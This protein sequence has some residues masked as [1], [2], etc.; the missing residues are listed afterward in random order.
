MG[1]HGRLER[2]SCNRPVA[3][4]HFDFLLML[5]DLLLKIF[6][7]FNQK[8]ASLFVAIVAAPRFIAM[9]TK[10]RSSSLIN[11]F[12][13][14]GWLGAR[15]PRDLY[16]T[17]LGVVLIL[18]ASWLS[19]SW[20]MPKEI[21]A[22]TMRGCHLGAVRV[23]EIGYNGSILRL[24]GCPKNDVVGGSKIGRIFGVWEKKNNKV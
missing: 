17:S 20:I 24:E 19:R 18:R 9:P 8:K 15:G 14:E 10:V 3:G 11:F 12:G 13:S 4:P 1:S 21:A 5:L 16:V 23:M 6:N 22:V 2:E 7:G